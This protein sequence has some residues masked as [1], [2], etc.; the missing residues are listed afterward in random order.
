ME[1]VDYETLQHGLQYSFPWTESRLH[2]LR[3]VWTYISL[4]KLLFQIAIELPQD[5]NDRKLSHSFG[6]HKSEKSKPQVTMVCGL[7]GSEKDS[8]HLF[9]LLVLIATPNFFVL[10]Q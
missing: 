6:S 7:C 3:K 9:L 8:N 2:H 1:R 5:E 10:W 4:S